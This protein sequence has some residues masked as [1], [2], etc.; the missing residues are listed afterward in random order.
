[1][2][3]PIK[4]P[5]SEI[6]RAEAL[7]ERNK[8]IPKNEYKESSSEYGA[9]HKNA[10]SDGDDKGRGVN[11][12]NDIGNTTDIGERVRLGLLNVFSKNNEYKNPE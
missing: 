5:A 6:L 10:L 2:A 1:M 12:V 8:L 9:T 7:K 3:D 4:T 11:G